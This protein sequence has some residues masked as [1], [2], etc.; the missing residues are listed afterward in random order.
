MKMVPFCPPATST[1]P[2][3]SRVAVCWSRAACRLPV[4]VQ[5]PVAGL[6]SSALVRKLLL[7][8]PAATSTC[9]VASSAAAGPGLAVGVLLVSPH[10]P[11]GGFDTAAVGGRSM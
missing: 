7:L 11:V 3:E 8:S 2:F 1:C 10:A 5:V 9:P 4:V 6:Y